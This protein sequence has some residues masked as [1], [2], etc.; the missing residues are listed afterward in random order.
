MGEHERPPAGR[1]ERD[2]ALPERGPGIA[3]LVTEHHLGGSEHPRPRG[4]VREGRR[5]PL[6][7]GGERDDRVRGDLAP[8]RVGV[9]EAPRGGV[10]VGRGAVP[11]QGVLVPVDGGEDVPVVKGD[12]ACGDG[13]GLVQAD[14]VDACETLD[15]RELVDEDL[16]VRELRRTDGERDR[17]DEHESERD[18]RGDRGDRVDHGLHPLAGFPRR[19]PTAEGDHLRVDDEQTHRAD[20]PAHPLQNPV[21]RRADLGGDEREAL[22]LRGEGVGVGIRADARRLGEALTRHDD[23]PGQRIIARAL[24]HGIRL[25]RQHRL[26]DLEGARVDDHRV[27]RDLVAGAQDQD[28]V[29]H[30]LRGHDLDVLPVATD[31]GARGVQQRQPVQRRLRA[32]LLPAADDRVRERGEAEQ[33][34]LPASEHEQ[35]EEAREDDAVEQREHVRADDVRHAPAGVGGEGVRP[36]VR[37]PLRDVRGHEPHGGIDLRPFAG[38]DHGIGGSGIHASQYGDALASESRMPE[39]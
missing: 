30:D 7:R 22:G 25:P 10:G 39:N 33:R 11:G 3:G 34:V 38:G 19:C 27:R 24:V 35:H 9:G 1:G 2:D 23:R 36:S 14:H 29:L 17:G 28:V 37:D 16:S 5:A 21:D 26:V 20:D 12:V 6:P 32:E 8:H 4:A 15:R 18:H 31:A 13:A